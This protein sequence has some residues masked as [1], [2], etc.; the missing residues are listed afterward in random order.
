MTKSYHKGE[1]N[2]NAVLTNRLARRIRELNAL[3]F[4]YGWIAQ[5]L[6]VSKSCVQKVCNGKAWRAYT[7]AELRKV[8]WQARAADPYAYQRS[9]RGK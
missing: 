9:R 6:G 8:A 4:G 1:R 2:P 7:T 3:G 5:W